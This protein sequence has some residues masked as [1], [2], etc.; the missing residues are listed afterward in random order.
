M[1]KYNRFVDPRTIGSNFNTWAKSWAKTLAIAAILL[2]VSVYSVLA[3]SAPRGRVDTVQSIASDGSYVEFLIGD[4]NPPKRKWGHVSL[5][6]VDADH[7]LIFDFGR[8]GAMWGKQAEG[9]PILRVWNH[10]LAAYRSYN[11]ADGGITRRYR[12]PSTV[13]R[14]KAIIDF[15]DTLARSGKVRTKTGSFTAY[16]ANYKTFHAVEVNCTTI[17]IDGF[18]RG[19]PEYNLHQSQYSEGRSLE[20]YLF[21]AAT[22]HG[23]YDS[24][25]RRW[26]R[27]WWPLDLMAELDAEFVARGLAQVGRL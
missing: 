11:L 21:A 16:V 8:Y 5:H 23:G 18:M 19:F 26:S 7:D 13:Q 14:N 3:H 24:G 2:I 4:R 6:V 12:F 17:S 22:G 20:F 15:F 1:K 10:Q 25:E 27:I 9:E